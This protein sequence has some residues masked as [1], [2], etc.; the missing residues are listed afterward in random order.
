MKSLVRSKLL[1]AKFSTDLVSIGAVIAD[2]KATTPTF[3]AILI[4]KSFYLK[5]ILL[6]W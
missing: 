5:K 4:L 1:F 6:L 3:I 2:M